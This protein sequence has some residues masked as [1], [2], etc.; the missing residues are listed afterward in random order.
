MFSKRF[1]AAFLVLLALSGTALAQ[2]ESLLI[3]PGDLI[4]VSIVDTPELEQQVRVTDHGTI[5]LAY[6]GEIPVAGDTP[7]A[8]AEEVRKRLVDRKVMWHP[9]V[10]VRVEEYATQDVTVLGQVKSP[11][12]YPISTPQTIVKILSLAGGLN[13]GADRKVTIKRHNSSTQ[14]T[15]YLSND[16]KEAFSDLLMVNPG[17]TVLVA[18]APLIFI[19]GDVNRPGGYSFT[20]ADTKL[21]LVQAIALAGSPN[22]TAQMNLRLLRVS[23]DGPK[24][25]DI[26]LDAIIKGKRPDVLLQPNDVV[27]VPFSWAKN[28]AM[29]SGQIA[30]STAGAAMYIIP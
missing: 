2:K 28:V 22:K 29:S 27:Y 21:T 15:Y 8:V 16:A 25:I 6:L 11:G 9:A 30:A 7:S 24:E 5:N 12:A 19:M 1:A 17:D 10:T 20:T 4:D 18:K 14:E 13:D 26:P 3:G 23:A